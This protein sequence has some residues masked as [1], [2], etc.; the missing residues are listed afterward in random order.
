MITE[1]AGPQRKRRKQEEDP[2]IKIESFVKFSQISVSGCSPYCKS[3]LT[4][5]LYCDNFQISCLILGKVTFISISQVKFLNKLQTTFEYISLT[6]QFYLS[7]LTSPNFP[8]LIVVFLFVSS[9]KKLTCL[10]KQNRQFV[11]KILKHSKLFF[12]DKPSVLFFTLYI[13]II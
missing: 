5:V 2:N 13:Y 3:T 1:G 12:I 4:L 7:L 6:R 10:S 11:G 9:S 8:F